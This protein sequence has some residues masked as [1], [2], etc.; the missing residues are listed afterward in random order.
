MERTRE[1][2]LE[3]ILRITI[4]AVL[5]GATGWNEIEGYAKAK[6]AWFRTLLE[7]PAGIPSHDTFNR[8]FSAL[9]SDELEKGFVEVVL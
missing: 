4:A 1:H 5:S 6:I 7:L 8:V 3:E 2:L 9:D